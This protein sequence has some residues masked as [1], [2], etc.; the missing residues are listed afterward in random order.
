MNDVKFFSKLYSSGLK[1]N[2]LSKLQERLE[3][4][5]YFL[6][7]R[8]IVY[9][10]ISA[11]AGVAWF[12]VESSFVFVLQ[13]FLVS[14]GI[15]ASSQTFLPAWYPQAVEMSILFLFG[16][17]LIRSLLFA[18]KLYLSERTNQAFIRHQ[19]SV[20]LNYA[21]NFAH[22][23][24]S[25]RILTLFNERMAQ[26]G[27]ILQQMN[28]MVNVSISLVLFFILGLRL[29]PQELMIGVFLLALFMAPFRFLEGRIRKLGKDLVA[30]GDR[31]MEILVVGMKN[32]FYLKLFSLVKKEVDEGE[33]YLR[34]FEKKNRYFYKM[35]A[36]RSAYPQFIGVMIIG[37]LTWVGLSY[38]QTPGMVLLS[39]FYIFLRIAQAASELNS[40][41]G[42]VRYSYEGFQVL[43]RWNL[44]ARK[45][46]HSLQ[47]REAQPSKDISAPQVHIEARGLTFGYDSGRPIFEG[48][49]FKV[50]PSELLLIKGPSGSG[51]STLVFLIL[52][53]LEPSRG[54]ISIN[55]DP[56]QLVR[57][58]LLE[59]V[60]YVGPEPYLIAGTVRQNLLYG[61]P[62][63][64]SIKDSQIWDVLQQTTL[65][66]LI[67]GLGF[68]LDQQLLE[69]AQLST[70]Q[71]Q[72]LALA[73]ALLR[74]PKLLILDEATANL[75]SD[76]ESKLLQTL[77]HLGK[78]ITMIV[79]S[80]RN[81]FDSMATHQILLGSERTEI[82]A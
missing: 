77:A 56:I 48:L 7:R 2:T 70:G 60:A 40:S 53:L 36:F 33:L 73:R 32:Y 71:K 15:V 29:A 67:Q 10:V 68:G 37:V 79:V 52:G 69:T 21:L 49:N 75:D 35:A 23:E 45:A 62:S 55:G 59:K 41:V 34:R 78:N 61:H 57:K 31:V 81:S 50:G 42:M 19:R 3:N 47:V 58:S 43:F 20:I 64:E 4:L 25:H 8:V 39:L 14:L 44:E 26:A 11:M 82:N 6:G 1:E 9:Y 74:F 16:F 80:H 30:D 46:L 76:T 12:A 63:P 27:G 66:K 24:S 51:K 72:R 54:Q 5:R 28:I 38:F 65:D 22:R 18:F 13:G 17:G